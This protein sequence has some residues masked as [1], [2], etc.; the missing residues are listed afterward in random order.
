MSNAPLN[1]AE[2]ARVLWEIDQEMT[3]HTRELVALR[4][5]LASLAR[6]ARLAHARAFL[7]AEGSIEAKK[8]IA[9]IAADDAKFALE[10][11]EQ[12]IEA[13]RDLLKTLQQRS[14]IGRAINS[15]L[16]E[17]LRVFQSGAVAA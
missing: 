10:V 6:E 4:L 14:E 16:K 3:G 2:A 5:Q 17:E 1:P 7:S 13:K 12:K 11:H 9:A 15:N 8:Q